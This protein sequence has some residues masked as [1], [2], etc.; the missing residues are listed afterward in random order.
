MRGVVLAKIAMTM[1]LLASSA[2]AS[3]YTLEIFGNANEDETINMQDVTYTEL[4]ILEYRDKTEL[5]DAKYDG[6][7]NMQDVTQIELVILGKEKELTVGSG[8]HR[9]EYIAVTV[10]KPIER[11]ITRFFDSAEVMRM[12]N[13][14]D[15]IV[16]V[17]TKMFQRNSIFFPCISELPYVAAKR[18]GPDIDYEAVFTLDPDIFFGWWCSE[19]RD[20]LPG[21]SL[22]HSKLWGFNSAKDVLKLGYIFDKEE[23]AEEYL[24]WHD[25]WIDM[26][27]ERVEEIPADEKPRVL[28]CL[29]DSAGTFTH[30]YRGRGGTT[31]M[32]ELIAMTCIR[33]VGEALPKTAKVDTEWVLEQNPDVIIVADCMAGTGNPSYAGYDLDDPS[34]IAAERDTFLNCPELA[35]ITAVKEGNVYMMDY[36]LFSYSQSMIVGAVY[37]AKWIYPGELE[38]MDP[39]AIHQE[40]LDRFQHIDYD[41]NEH[42]V[43]AYPPIE[44]DSGLAG[45]P[46]RYRG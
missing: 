38:D 11:V 24:D 23:E 16:G 31:G 43:F 22:I 44:I 13:A 28:V 15:K 10:H 27:K 30:V 6:K 14:D 17:G 29:F 9:N 19:T 40:Y 39:E 26:I 2:A 36:K 4:I 32:D 42:G 35:E 41:L 20:K 34:R 33:N 46:D 18:Y 21:I 37:I 1:L 45:I 25:G 7:I 12:L 3:D 8:D 5:S